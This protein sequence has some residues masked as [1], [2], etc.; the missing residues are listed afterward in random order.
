MKK[1]AVE[2]IRL[3]DLPRLAWIARVNP[4]NDVRVYH[5]INVER[6]DQWLVEGVWDGEFGLGD[7][8]RSSFFFGSGMRVSDNG[9]YFTTSSSLNSRLLCCRY[10][11][12]ILVS[13]SLIIL[14]AYTDAKL[15]QEHDYNRECSSIVRSVDSYDR[16]FRVLHP[17]IEYFQQ[18]FFEN[19]FVSHGQISF[20]PREHRTH[21]E[22]YEDYI[23]QLM[24]ILYRI[25]DNY[26]DKRRRFSVDAFSTISSGYDSTAVA[27]LVRKIGVSKC[28]TSRRSNSVLPVCFARA[29]DDGTYVGRKLGMSV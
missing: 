1:E 19:I 28:F 15:D 9:V 5:G 25:R 14:L 18:V 10:G 11:K 4:S 27:C 17:S 13:N 29:S 20:K 3:P 21:I 6:H 2:H 8:H 7:F 12:D 24:S 26:T 22:S 16:K 23:E